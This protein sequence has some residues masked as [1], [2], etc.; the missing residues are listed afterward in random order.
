M[1]NFQEFNNCY[2]DPCVNGSCIDGDNTYSCSCFD[3][4]K[5]MVCDGKPCVSL[6]FVHVTA[7]YV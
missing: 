2:P 6:N 5:G 4:Y 1:F 3:G 7:E